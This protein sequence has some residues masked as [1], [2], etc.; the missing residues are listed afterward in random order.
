M[1][2]ILRLDQRSAC[3]HSKTGNLCAWVKGDLE[4]DYMDTR[5]NNEVHEGFSVAVLYTCSF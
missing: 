5:T 4:N 2:R 1:Y 3:V